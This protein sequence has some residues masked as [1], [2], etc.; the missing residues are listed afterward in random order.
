MTRWLWPA[1]LAAAIAT[2]GWAQKPDM[3]G[4]WQGT[5]EAGPVKLRL[6]LHVTRNASGEYSSTFDSIDQG[7]MSL[8]VALTKVEGTLLHFEMPDLRASFDGELSEDGKSIEGGFTQGVTLP[9]IFR[10]VSE[11]ETL[12][13]PQEPKPPFPYES[14]NVTYENKAG[15]VRLAGTLTRPRGAGPFPAVIL[16]TGSGPQDRDETIMGHKPFLVIADSLT[17]RGIAV[18]RVDD[19]GVGG[20]TGR[21]M[22]ATLEDAAGDV[23]AAVAFLKGRREV[24]GARI[25]VIGHSEGGIV[26]PMAATKSSDIAFVVMLAGSGVPGDQVVYLQGELVARSAGASE[27]A[28]AE[29]RE[30]QRRMVEILRSE[31]DEFVAVEKV[32]TAWAQGREPLPA[33]VRAQVDA[34]IAVAASPEIRSLLLHDPAEDLRKLKVPVL[35]LNGSRD[36][37]VSAGQNLPPIAAALAAGENPDFTVMALPGLNHLF[38]KCVTCTVGEYSQIEE[39]FSPAAL[40]LMGDWIV[41]HTRSR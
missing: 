1:A 32:R 6:G 2:G 27:A 7:A 40:E 33:A 28:I 30:M 24:D 14:E 11:V 41:R 16:I 26:G 31:K 20:S 4:T 36:V 23:L 3:A 15:G 22:D 9:L 12:R 37:Q 29:S 18:L 17:R 13:R 19:R 35:A 25:G 10:R 39:T 21:S 8:P 38:Q 34:Q 5:L